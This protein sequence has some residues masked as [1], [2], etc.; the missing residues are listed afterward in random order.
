[1]KLFHA[2]IGVQLP[3]W[4]L[5]HFGSR[6]AALERLQH[7]IKSE[8]DLARIGL[9]EVTMQSDGQHFIECEDF[10]APK[11]EAVM[12]VCLGD[13]RE[14]RYLISQR[15]QREIEET[16][17]TKQ[18][19]KVAARRMAAEAIAHT[20]YGL[21]YRN[22][23]EDA[24]EI[25]YCILK[26]DFTEVKSYPVKL[27]SPRSAIIELDDAVAEL[28]LLDRPELNIR[29]QVDRYAALTLTTNSVAA[30]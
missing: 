9:F 21:R 1:M 17:M 28:N 12:G 11:P 20:C 26:P 10:G 5:S 16:D 22:A 29:N 18:E 15:I 7:T 19:K 4:P 2:G 25:S 24:G 14:T 8:A 30:E 6:L 27:S 13:D 3:F 23:F